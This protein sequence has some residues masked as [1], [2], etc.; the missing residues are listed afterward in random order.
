MSKNS[1][2]IIL[3]TGATGRQGGAVY[4]HLQQ[5]GFKLRTLVRDPDSNKA[6]QRVGHGEGVFQ[7]GFDDPDSLLRAMDGVHGVF[8][9]QPY[10]A[11]EIQQGVAVIEAAKRRGVSHFVYSSVASADEETGLPHFENKVKVEEHLRSSGLQYTIVRPVFF[12]ENWH[13]G[14]GDSIRDGQLQQPLSSTAKLQMIAVDDIGAFA[15]LAFEHPGQWK[16]RIFSL[17]GDELSMQ[18]IAD[19]FSRVTARDV[20]YVQVSWD[21]FEKDM[22]RELTAMYHWFE[23]KGFHFNTDEARREYPLTHTFNRWLDA[24]WNTTAVAAR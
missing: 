6:R 3:V 16:N 17:A 7:G 2:R 12:M 4:K 8:S 5:K 14:F 19:A 18:Q 1:E 24:S 9:V 23:E 21:Q 20:K 15:A 10:T 22:G 11:N 13:R